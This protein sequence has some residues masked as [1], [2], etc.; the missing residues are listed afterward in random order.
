MDIPIGF[1]SNIAFVLAMNLMSCLAA[2][3]ALLVLSRFGF[4]RSYACPWISAALL[5]LGVLLGMI[6]GIPFLS[7]LQ[8]ILC[9]LGLFLLCIT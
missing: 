1:V 5:L 6:P 9:G 4:R 2:L 8:G 7:A 3:V